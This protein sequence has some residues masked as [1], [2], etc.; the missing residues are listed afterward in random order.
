V[1][2]DFY[3]VLNALNRLISRHAKSSHLLIVS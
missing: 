2:T 1:R 3:E